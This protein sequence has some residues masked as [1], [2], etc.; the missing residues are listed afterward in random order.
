[1]YTAGEKFLKWKNCLKIFQ[2]KD[3]DFTK[4]YIYKNKLSFYSQ[5]MDLRSDRDY[6]GTMVFPMSDFFK[7]EI[8]IDEKKISWE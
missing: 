1:M 2:K 3:Y 6:N 7:S 5:A 8:T 4:K